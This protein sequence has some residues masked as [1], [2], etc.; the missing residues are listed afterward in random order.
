MPVDGVVKEV[1]FELGVPDT[2]DVEAA[3]VEEK[4]VESALYEDGKLSRVRFGR[5]E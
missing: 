2:V 1:E 5:E 3:P 4:C